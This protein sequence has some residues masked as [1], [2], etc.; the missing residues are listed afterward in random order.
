MGPKTLLKTLKTPT[1]HPHHTPF[2]NPNSQRLQYPLI[3]EY[4]LIILGILLLFK[5]R[6][7]P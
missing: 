2:C 6:Y 1:L 3:K 4:T 5:V 7:I